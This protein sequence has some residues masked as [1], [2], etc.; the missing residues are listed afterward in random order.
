MRHTRPAT[1]HHHHTCYCTLQS[2]LA[3]RPRGAVLHNKLNRLAGATKRSAEPARDAVG[4]LDVVVAGVFLVRAEEGAGDA[5]VGK[6]A[7]LITRRPRFKQNARALN[8]RDA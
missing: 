8:F 6:A 1:S 3:A 5:A 7:A 2:L 4:V